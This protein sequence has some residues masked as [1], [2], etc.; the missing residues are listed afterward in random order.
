MAISS[1]GVVAALR[2]GRALDPSGF[3][4]TISEGSAHLKECFRSATVKHP[5]THAALAVLVLALGAVFVWTSCLIIPD[6]WEQQIPEAGSSSSP[7]AVDLTGDGVRDIVMG[8]GGHEFESSDF[9][10]IA[11][12]GQDG[13]PLWSVPARDQVVGSPTFNDLNGDGTPDVVIGGRSAV[14]YAIDG[15]TGKRIWEFLPTHDSLDI[16]NDRD[17][18]N[19]Y[20]PQF[21]PDQDGDGLEDLLTA[22]GGFISAPPSQTDRPAGRLM[23]ISSRDG[24]MLA[25]ATMPDGQETYMSPVVY[26]AEGEKGLTVLFG[27]GGETINGHFYKT[28]LAS[29]L[30]EDLSAATELAN[31]RGKGFIAPPVLADFNEDGTRDI[32]VNS[33]KGRVLAFDG[34]TEELLWEANLDGNFEGYTPPSPGHFDED[35]DLD[36]FVSYGHRPGLSMSFTYQAVVDGADGTVVMEDTVGTFQYASPLTF[37]LDADGLDEALVVVNSDHGTA[38]KVLGRRFT[39]EMR[40]YDP[41]TQSTRRLEPEEERKVGLNLGSTP[42]LTDLDGDGYLDVIYCY[43]EEPN[44]FFSFRSLTIE[45]TELRVELGGP[46]RW[47]EYMGPHH[48]GVYGDRAPNEPHRAIPGE[49]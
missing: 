3:R 44:D 4:K 37:D 41:H 21:I 15:E 46:I 10:V 38:G 5:L 29:V 45:R 30:A 9:G 31:G 17:I 7:K 25:E 32:V 33:V 12:D 40:L 28:S 23:V 20:N 34:A 43:M 16:R 24:R 2:T 8:A 49:R 42:L 48:N 36:V 39:N 6:H 26:D 47:G 1:I 14:L 27:S 19:F 11:L 18:L 35:E 22:Y 13:A